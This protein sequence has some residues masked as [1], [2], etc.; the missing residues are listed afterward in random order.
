MGQSTQKY[1]SK[2]KKKKIDFMKL[3][4]VADKLNKIILNNKKNFKKI[5]KNDQNF[6]LVIKTMR[7]LKKL[8]N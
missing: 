3:N 8:E 6:H 4:F 7:K 2:I 1:V 5:N